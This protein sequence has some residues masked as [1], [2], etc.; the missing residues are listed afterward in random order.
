MK[1]ENLLVRAFDPQDLDPCLA[2]FDSNCPQFFAAD[3]REKFVHYLIHECLPYYVVID[4]ISRMVA[5][6]GF[7]VENKVAELTWGMADRSFHGRGIGLL[8]F[9]F[10]L[11]QIRKA[12]AIA[13]KMDTSQHSLGFYLKL[14]FQIE[15]KAAD[16]YEPGL[17]RYD[18]WMDLKIS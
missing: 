4:G 8:L 13:L 12:R 5:C 1:P 7:L 17:D 10:R 9:K 18:L 16:G 2:I 15:N 3:E 6:G 11:E 14:G